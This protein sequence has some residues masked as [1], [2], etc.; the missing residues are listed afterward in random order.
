M[1]YIAKAVWAARTVGK[2]SSILLK[3][4]TFTVF[5]YGQEKYKNRGSGF[6]SICTKNLINIKVRKIPIKALRYTFLVPGFWI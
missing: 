5:F 1:K 2:I 3:Y 4:S 6:S